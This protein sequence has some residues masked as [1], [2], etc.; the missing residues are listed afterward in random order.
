M[1]LAK[2]AMHFTKRL[3]DVWDMGARYELRTNLVIGPGTQVEFKW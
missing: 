1:A 3:S 2:A